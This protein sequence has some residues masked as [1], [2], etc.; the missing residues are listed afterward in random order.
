MNRPEEALAHGAASILGRSLTPRE[1]TEFGK[2]LELLIQWQRVHRFVGS[3]DPVWIVEHLF[4]D[5]LLFLRLLPSTA[6]TVLDLGSGA[7]VPGLPIKIVRRDIELTLIES[8]RRRAS[9]LSTVVRELGL[10]RTYVVADRVEDRSRELE[11][12]FDAVV[13]R[14]AGD[15]GDLIP[16]A[17][18]LV[19]SQGVIIAAG[20]PHPKPL[21][22]GEWVTVPGS[23][24]GT[25]RRLAV[26]RRP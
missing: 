23:K 26:H 14:C 18:R 17:S 2:Y 13:M 24:A 4:L 11:G 22:M 19:V 5:S 6:R 20:P 1:A 16:L 10:D 7:G 12:R 8:R 21:A 15:V 25:T 3:T 9:F